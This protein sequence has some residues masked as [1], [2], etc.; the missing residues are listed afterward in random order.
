[1][2]E[3]LNQYI[4]NCKQKSCQQNIIHCDYLHKNLIS[5][6]IRMTA[7]INFELKNVNLKLI[8]SD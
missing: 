3:I 7:H 1:M 6:T 4:H 2:C 5:N 8:D